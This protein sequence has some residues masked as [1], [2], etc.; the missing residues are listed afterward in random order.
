[1]N[2]LKGR[3]TRQI[4]EA[5]KGA[6]YVWVNSDSYYPRMLARAL[7]REDLM[8]V[9]PS[10]LTPGNTLGRSPTPFVLDP[11]AHHVLTGNQWDIFEQVRCRWELSRA[12]VSLDSKL[13]RQ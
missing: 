12:R 6:F 13:N 7:G 4:H 5:P 11:A 2:K 9:G 3:T 8:I 10:W 1:V